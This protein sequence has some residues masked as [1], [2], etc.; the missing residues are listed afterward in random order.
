MITSK[1]KTKILQVINVFE[2]GK[3]DGKYDS[4][5]RYKD[6]PNK[7]RQITYGRSQTTEYGNLKRLI[8]NYV[9][10]NGKFA[11]DFEPY[12]SKI[13]NTALTDDQVF[14]NLLKTSACKDEMM[15]KCQDDFFDLYYYQ[16]AYV[17]FKGFGFKE[18]LSLLVIYDSYIHSGGILNFLRKRFPERPPVNGGK[19]GIWIEQ[20][21][22]T[23]HDWLATHSNKI[24]HKTVYRTNCFKE[25]MK[26]KNWLLEKPVIANGVTLI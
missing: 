1:I 13:G 20:Y 19:E 2:T 24:L 6:G 10:M 7:I 21:V 4:I 5:V 8:E 26:N 17:W 25:Q 11:I 23:R 3:P 15:C 16:P 12:V 14:I 9:S 22:N 18:P